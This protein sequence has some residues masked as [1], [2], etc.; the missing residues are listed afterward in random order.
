MGV[1]HFLGLMPD[2]LLPG[3]RK[4]GVELDSITARIAQRLYRGRRH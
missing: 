3:A 1:G 2:E 4:T